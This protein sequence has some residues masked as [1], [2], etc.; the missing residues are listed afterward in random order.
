MDIY[1]FV[2]PMSPPIYI[3]TCSTLKFVDKIFIEGAMPEKALK[4]AFFFK[5]F[6]VLRILTFVM[7]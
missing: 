3:Y 5:E 7:D 2:Y 4:Y 6:K 1:I